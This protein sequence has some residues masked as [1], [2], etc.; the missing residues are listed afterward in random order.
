MILAPNLRKARAFFLPI[1][2]SLISIFYVRFH[3]RI[4]I[5][6]EQH[7]V[8]LL[9]V[10][11]LVHK[12]LRQQKPESTR[13]KAFS[14]SNGDVAQKIVGWAVDGRVAK[15]FKREALTGV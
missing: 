1:F 14:F 2:N 5:F 4:N 13:P 11:E 10:N 7:L 3:S 12:L 15:L 8:A 6:D 9:A